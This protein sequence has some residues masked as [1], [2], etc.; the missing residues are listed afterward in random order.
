VRLLVGPLSAMV[1]GD[2]PVI[3]EADPFGLLVEPVADWNVEISDFTV[4][5]GVSSRGLVEGILIVED[6]L[7]EVAEAIFVSFVQDAGAGFAVSDGLKEAICDSL[8]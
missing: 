1:S 5:K 2:R 6:A 8:E 3:I 7:F 4:V